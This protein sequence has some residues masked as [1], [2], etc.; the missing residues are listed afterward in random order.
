MKYSI[1]LFAAFLIPS[2]IQPEQTPEP[3]PKA[4]VVALHGEATFEYLPPVDVSTDS[5]NV[6]VVT[7][8][9]LVC[10]EQNY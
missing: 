7:C 5:N 2:A 3:Q 10:V 8:Y 4:V 9:D 6:E 1:F